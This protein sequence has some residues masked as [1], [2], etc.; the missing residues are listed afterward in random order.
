LLLWVSWKMW[1]VLRA[2]PYNEV[3][4]QEVATG[5]DLNRDGAVTAAAPTKT[6]AQ[7]AMQIVIADVS[8]SL[9]KVLAVA[10][11]GAAQAHP[12]VLAFGLIL[13]IALMGLA[14][15]F[16]ARLLS[17]YRWIAYVGLA[18]ILCVAGEMICNGGRE[19]MPLLRGV[20]YEQIERIAH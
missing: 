19:L 1:Q 18:I 3:E 14:A 11:A 4:E 7:A 20:P 17:K 9:D 15:T 8:M 2:G 10:G 6:L 5:L 16:I 13:S 12:E